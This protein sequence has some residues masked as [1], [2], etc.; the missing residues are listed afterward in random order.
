MSVGPGKRAEA[1]EGIGKDMGERLENKV[2]TLNAKEKRKKY[3]QLGV[4]GGGDGERLQCKR[5]KPGYEVEET[6]SK[7]EFLTP[8]QMQEQRRSKKGYSTLP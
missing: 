1:A 5:K 2:N 8:A 4:G 7:K 6:N 3:V